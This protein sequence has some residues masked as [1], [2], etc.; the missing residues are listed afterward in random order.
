VYG[1]S[2]Y[3]TMKK[4]FISILLVAFATLIGCAG[5]NPIRQNPYT[6]NYATAADAYA[7]TAVASITNGLATTNYVNVATNGLATAFANYASTN[8]VIAAT[9]DLIITTNKIDATFY[10]LVTNIGSGGGTPN[11]LTNNETRNTTFINSLTASNVTAKYLTLVDFVDGTLVPFYSTD[12]ELNL[13]QLNISANGLYAAYS[14][15]VAPGGSFYGDGTGITGITGSNSIAAG[16]ID[17]NRMDATAYAAFIGGGTPDALTNNNATA[18]TLADNLTVSG[19]LLTLGAGSAQNT[20]QASAALVTVSASIT[21]NGSNIRGRTIIGTNFVGN[22][23]SLTNIHGSNSIAE[24]TISTNRMDAT[25]YAAFIGGG[26][27][28]DPNALTN[29]E[30]RNVVLNGGLKV[31]NSQTLAAQFVIITNILSVDGAANISNMFSM[32]YTGNGTGIT[33]IHGS[34]SIAAGTID[35]NKMDATAYAAFIGGGTPDALTNSETR[36][37]TFQSTLTLDTL[38]AFSNNI[39]SGA[40][41][42]SPYG[43]VTFRDMTSVRGV[44][45]NNFGFYGNGASLTNIHGSNSIAAGTIDTNKM[46]ATAYAAFIGGG[47]TADPNALTNRDT[48][49]IVFQNSLTISNNGN[50]GGIRMFDAIGNS[51]LF[52]NTG[53]MI[54]FGGGVMASS[55]VG[56]GGSLSDLSGTTITGGTVADARIADEIARDAELVA[57]DTVVSNGVI[58]FVVLRTNFSGIIVTNNAAIG[59]DAFITNTLT[60]N[61]IRIFNT[62]AQG[63]SPDASGSG[64]H[65]EGYETIA[66]GDYSHAEGINT[67]ASNSYSHAEGE[68][69]IASGIGSHAEGYYSLASGLDAHAEGFYSTASG[70]YSHAEGDTTIASGDYS[71]AEGDTTIASGESSHAEGQNTVASG[72]YS[73]AGGRGATAGHDTTWVWSSTNVPALTSTAPAQFSVYATGGI[74][75]L[76]G[77]IYGNGAGLTNIANL[78]TAAYSNSE[79]FRL[80][81]NDS[82]TNIY[83]TNNATIGALAIGNSLAQANSVASGNNSSA[84]GFDNAASGLYS[85]A[86]GEL[87]IAFGRSSHVEGDGNYANGISSHAEGSST[88]ADGDYSHAEGLQTTA[89]GLYSHSGGRKAYATNTATWV[90]ADGTIAAFGSTVANEFSV[91][92]TGGIR[93][94]GG[95]ISG[96]GSGLT[97]LTLSNMAGLGTAAYSNSTAFR[98]ISNDNFT[99][100]YVT[101][102]LVVGAFASAPGLYAFAQGESATAVGENSHAQG[103]NTYAYGLNAHA[104]GNATEAYGSH[105]HAQ[106]EGT[107]ADG[108][109]SHAEGYQ[110]KATNVASHAEGVGTLASNYASHAEGYQ[111]TAS[112]R[113]SHAEGENT[114]ASGDYSHAEGV[115]GGGTGALGLA[116]HAE[117]TQTT[118]SGNY[119]HAEG[120]ET[121]ASGLASH[122][123]GYQTLAQGIYSHAAGNDAEAINNYSWVWAS[124]LSNGVAFQD[125]AASQFAV[126]ATGGIRLLGSPIY[127][128]GSGLSNVTATAT[129]YTNDT[130]L[131]GVVNGYSIG[132]N[133]STLATVTELS[134]ATNVVVANLSNGLYTVS[135]NGA[136]LT[137]LNFSAG[138]YATNSSALTN[139][140]DMTKPYSAATVNNT[141]TLT[142]LSGVSAFATNVQWAVRFYTNTGTA[143]AVNFPASWIGNTVGQYITNQSVISIVIYPGFG[144]NVVYRNL[145]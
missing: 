53:A 49:A 125:T 144:T 95:A 79:A 24:G 74:R 59:N 9:N 10:N 101:N 26:I 28:A 123:Q 44:G 92:A 129:P 38:I 42:V 40:F 80:I 51:V 102:R 54:T 55:F 116:S 103:Y 23:A 108:N 63:Y 113:S 134:S 5:P 98:L 90:W 100:I 128:D 17:T 22:G 78:G 138:N 15:T 21:A 137:N 89:S 45:W 12:F 121:V 86:Q 3:N 61:N 111:T 132:T 68:N 70:D 91:R 72:L 130:G 41:T 30:T 2:Y 58:D 117:G 106:G 31:G 93:L 14:V 52:S 115:G 1:N 104:E 36:A 60:A 29:N 62:V 18:V 133:L 136:G 97:N 76:G 75:L 71:H 127:G 114:I 37:V 84:L 56:D 88:I 109:Y 25:A 34:N 73:H 143:G 83:V 11:A 139:V 67:L 141:L 99:N 105:S 13:S 140:I 43:D 118:A 142:G 48:R 46:D 122:A 119:S 33:N 47:I 94:L 6:T 57:A 35:T 107:I 27:T 8:Y 65:A 64:S 87:N 135:G 81:S 85:H 19:G 131:P 20:L 66:L 120:I 7:R 96:N 50:A 110:T 32:S 112:G 77:P 4:L 39:G 16:T 145:K 82:F 69:T 126:Y 124:G